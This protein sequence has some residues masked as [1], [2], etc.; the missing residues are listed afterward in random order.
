MGPV[1]IQQL[2]VAE[3][4]RE[5]HKEDLTNAARE[6]A[7]T[8]DSPAKIRL[9]S[10]NGREEME[11]TLE[12]LLKHAQ[13]FSDFKVPEKFHEYQRKVQASAQAIRQLLRNNQMGPVAAKLQMAKDET[14]AAREENLKT[15]NNPPKVLL[16]LHTGSPEEMSETQEKLLRPKPFKVPEKFYEYPRKVERT[17]AVRQLLKGDL[18]G[19]VTTQLQTGNNPDKISLRLRITRRERAPLLRLRQKLHAGKLNATG[20]ARLGSGNILTN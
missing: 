13:A 12:K 1:K 6:N 7:R 10:H 2:P 3:Y 14:N 20:V 19:P 17:M 5:N 18:Y 11:E 15:G 8:G 16:K 4:L 9:K